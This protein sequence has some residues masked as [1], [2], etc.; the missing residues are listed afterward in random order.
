MCSVGEK[1]WRLNQLENK[2][3]KSFNNN[4]IPSIY[5]GRKKE[6]VGSYLALCDLLVLAAGA[7]RGWSLTA[8]DPIFSSTAYTLAA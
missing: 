7:H 8:S 5:Y 6:T 4:Y 3:I 1:I 2:N